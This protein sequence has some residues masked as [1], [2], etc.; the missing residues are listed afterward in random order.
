MRSPIAKRASLYS[1]FCTLHSREIRERDVF[2]SATLLKSIV[3]KAVI[4]LQFLLYGSDDDYSH[5]GC[6]AEELAK[7]YEAFLPTG[8]LK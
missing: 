4:Q 6:F 1:V 3:A 2:Y 7:K 8:L 5:F